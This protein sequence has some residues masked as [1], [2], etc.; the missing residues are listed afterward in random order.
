MADRICSIEGC[1]TRHYALGWCN[2]HWQKARRY[3][4]P[5]GE[6]ATQKSKCSI[7]ACGEDVASR[8]WCK[9][10][11]MSWYRHGDPLWTSSDLPL[12]CSL[13][14]SPRVARGWCSAHYQKWVKYGDPMGEAPPRKPK[15]CKFPS[16]PRPHCARGYCEIHWKHAKRGLPLLPLEAGI[17]RKE[18]TLNHH[19]FD[20]ITDERCAYWLGF[21][22]ADGCMVDHDGRRRLVVELHER[23]A[24]HLRLLCTDLGS[25]PQLHFARACVRASFSSKRIFQALGDLGVHPR[26]SATVKPWD[27]PAHLMPHYW[28]GMVDGDG[29]IT[30]TRGTRK[31]GVGLYGSE[32]CVSGF[33][34]WARTVCDAAAVPHLVPHGGCWSWMVKGTKKPQSLANALYSAADLALDRKRSRAEL[35]IQTNFDRSFPRP[36]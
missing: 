17:R 32:A 18:R 34:S 2:H 9:S 33:A 15:G 29:T 8:G 36:R 23:D 26:K 14:E 24:D 35:L 11:Y 28:R 20:E 12:S 1:G 6:P 7:P 19:Y 16:C 30:H 4:D 13:C 5:L 25:D 3:G 27:G 22:T 31:W 10:H 21:I